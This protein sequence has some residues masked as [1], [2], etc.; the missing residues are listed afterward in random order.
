MIELTPIP[1][2]PMTSRRSAPRRSTKTS[3]YRSRRRLETATDRPSLP[4]SCSNGAPAR[5]LDIVSAI[6]VPERGAWRRS[7][8]RKDLRENFCVPAPAARARDG[9]NQI[10]CAKRLSI[11]ART[12]RPHRIARIA[13]PRDAP[14]DCGFSIPA[15]SHELMHPRQARDATFQLR[16]FQERH[17]LGLIGGS[18]R[19][20]FANATNAKS[21]ERFCSASVK[22][23]VPNQKF[24]SE[25]RVLDRRLPWVA[26]RDRRYL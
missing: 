10:S 12:S 1:N 23:L 16:Q 24:D 8:F 22:P 4:P 25:Y 3:C 17:A 15:R 6:R 20:S 26:A 14:Q 18:I 7:R 19:F 5:R 9:A 13:R 21:L 11:C 2:L